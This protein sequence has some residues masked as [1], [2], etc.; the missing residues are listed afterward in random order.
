MRCARTKMV[1]DTHYNPYKISSPV[2]DLVS[3]RLLTIIAVEKGLSMHLLDISS[4][5]LNADLEDNREIFIYP[6]KCYEVGKTIVGSLTNLFMGCVKADTI[7]TTTSV[8]F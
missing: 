1:E 7:G 8:E 6:P 2:V 5:Y 3:I 4:A